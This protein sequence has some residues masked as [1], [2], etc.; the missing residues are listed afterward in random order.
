MRDGDFSM[1][2]EVREIRDSREF[3]EGIEAFV[4]QLTWPLP[5]PFPSAR[6]DLAEERAEIVA[7]IFSK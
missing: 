1:N 3:D 7:R 5:E 6:L 2:A 4:K